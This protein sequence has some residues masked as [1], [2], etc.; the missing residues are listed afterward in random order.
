MAVLK[1][2]FR[3]VILEKWSTN[4]SCYR[5]EETRKLKLHTSCRSYRNHVSFNSP[6][7]FLALYFI[8]QNMY[9]QSHLG[10]HFPKLRARSSNVS[11]AMFRWKETLELWAL[12]LETAFENVTPSGIGC[13]IANLLMPKR[14]PQACQ[15]HVWIAAEQV[16]CSYINEF[17]WMLCTMDSA[18]PTQSIIY[19]T[20]DV[21]YSTQLSFWVDSDRICQ[22]E[23]ICIGGVPVLKRH[24][25]GAGP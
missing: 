8:T 18:R 3:N 24:F 25:G 2:N 19:V 16:I 15:D 17:D 12:S 13:S 5:R 23:M 4:W 7:F 21:Y 11:F 1:L 10:C 22:P 6:V 20:Y 9:S 14:W